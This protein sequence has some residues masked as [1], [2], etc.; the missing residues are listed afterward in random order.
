LGITALEVQ[1]NPFTSEEGAW[2]E[3]QARAAAES[4]GLV[5]WTDALQFVVAHIE[6]GLRRNLADFLGLQEVEN[7]LSE[8]S[9]DAAFANLVQAALPDETAR[10]RFARLLRLLAR[11]R[12]PL[13]NLKE[14][15]ESVAA[16]GLPKHDLAEVLQAA[17]LRLKAQL[18]GNQTDARQITLPPEVEASIANSIHHQT[19]KTFFAILPEDTQQ[20]LSRI[21]ELVGKHDAHDVLVTRDA[22]LRPFVRRL[23]E[24][25]FPDLMVLASEELIS[26]RSPA[27]LSNLNW[28]LTTANNLSTSLPTTNA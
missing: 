2:I 28:D 12:V 6:A 17:R 25:E 26:P 4:Q 23:V 15:L 11:E 27:E 22:S 19:G 8:R 20:L 5:V 13:T 21:R 9:Q 14:I 3:P 10:L 1:A 24:V 7:T 18:P 16:T